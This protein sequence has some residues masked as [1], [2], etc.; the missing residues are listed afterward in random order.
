MT[1]E[2]CVRLRG[3][4]AALHR[5]AP[6]WLAVWVR[7]LLGVLATARPV[8]AAELSER[9]ARW[10]SDMGFSGNLELRRGSQVLARVDALDIAA[11][12]EPPTAEHAFWI[13]SISKQFAAAAILRLVERGQLALASP[14]SSYFHQ[15][16]APSLSKNG[17]SCSIEH[18]LSHS[19][20]LPRV[21][22]SDSLHTA[23]HLSD[24]A[25]AERLFEQLARTPLMFEP[26][27]SYSY[28]NVGYALLGLLIQQVSGQSYESFLQTELWGPLGMRT[29]G[30]SPHSGVNPVRGQLRL[31][32][33]WLDSARWMLLDPWTP[34]TLGAGGAIY[35]TLGDLLV[36]N[37][38]L[39][40]GR[41]LA[42]ESYSA[43]TRPRH[44][45]YGFGLVITKKPFGTLI[46]HAGSHSP[47]SVSAMLLYVPELDLSLAGGSSRSYEDSGL[48]PLGEALLASAAHSPVVSAP[49]ASDWDEVLLS[50]LL[51]LLQLAVVGYALYTSWIC[52]FGRL[53]LDLRRTFDCV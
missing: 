29:T 16:A 33:L 6:W 24:A 2:P 38:A 34:S 1:P 41:V 40:H 46:S 35:S 32:P 10:A 12:V 8:H 14:I 17:V 44:G 37:D 50:S 20:G 39:H 28:S 7:V 51:A 47:Q 5:V 22:G 25:R 27:T 48:K 19:C 42:P 9:A 23:R 3:A 43:M 31:G 45:D 36:W 26:G 53:Q 11:P 4:D 15:L 18:L 13:G 49:R 30:I 52:Y 21:L